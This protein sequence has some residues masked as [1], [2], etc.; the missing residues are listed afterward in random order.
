VTFSVAA[1]EFHG[2]RPLQVS[3]KFGRGTDTRKP[4][5]GAGKSP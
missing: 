3:L 4:V 5:R 1:W 2:R